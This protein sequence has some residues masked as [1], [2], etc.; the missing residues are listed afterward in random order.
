MKNKKIIIIGAGP[1]GLTAGYELKDSGHKVVIFE[2]DN[3]IGGISKTV[4]HNGNRMDIGGHRFFSKN[5][6]IMKWWT[7]ILP[8]QGNS[9]MDEIIL[10]KKG[11]YEPNGPD[12]EKSDIVMLHRNRVSRI[13]YLRKFFDYPISLRMKTFVNMGLLRTI[14]A[15]FGYIFSTIIKKE[16]NSLENFYINRFGMPLYRMFFENY[17]EKVWGV[18]PSKLGADWGSQRVKGLSLKTVIKDVLTR[19]LNKESV[20]QKD[21][22][23]SLI[24][25]F[26]YPKYGPGQLWEA[27]AGIIEEKG[28]SVIKNHAVKKINIENNR[29]CSV[30]VENNGTE[31]VE[32]CDYLLSSMP[33]KDLIASIR[34][35]EIPEEIKKIA[36]NLPYRDFITVG[37]MFDRLLIR[38]ETK[39]KTWNDVV[40]DTWI[41]IQDPDVKIGRLQIFNN[42]SPYMVSD[43]KNTVW[44]GLEYFCNEGDSLWRMSD[45]EF[46]DMAINELNKIG[47]IDVKEAKDAIRVKVKKA[48]PSYYGSY[49]ELSKVI[50]FLN[51]IP[52]LYCIGRNGQHRYNNMD[53]SMLTSIMAVEH[54]LGKIKDKTL[55]WNVNVEKEYHEKK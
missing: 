11:S 10:N 15:G 8:L 45:E 52:N 16:E 43:F 37:L 47:I 40:P 38:N 49:Y 31:K 30:V 42:W 3:Q 23:T 20:Y 50:D 55:I 33:I 19:T 51:Q 4:E 34:G 39:M 5:Y 6:E 26:I 41:Y 53:H 2:E 44:V 48:Y 25:S 28:E 14:N 32:P 7:S 21:K 12:P 1:A 36:F 9:S 24:E 18:H 29:V 54:I 17:T 22:E 13:F 27:V 46:I 35:I